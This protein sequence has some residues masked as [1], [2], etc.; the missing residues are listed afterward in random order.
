MYRHEGSFTSW[1]LPP[2]AGSCRALPSWVLHRN[3][4]V[5]AHIPLDLQVQA[6]ITKT[7]SLL[8]FTASPEE[9]SPCRLLLLQASFS[10]I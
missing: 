5:F 8:S 7:V 6:V 4:P 10:G 9:S 1:S 2:W 3:L